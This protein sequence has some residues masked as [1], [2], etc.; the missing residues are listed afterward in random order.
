MNQLWRFLHLLGTIAWL[1]GAFSSMVIGAR[2]KGGSP[3]VLGTVAGLQSA[4]H[5]ILIGPGALVVALSGLILTL[6]LIGNPAPNPWLMAMQGTGLLGAL[7]VLFV[8][9]PTA[10]KLGRIS[11][12]GQTGPLF[13]QLRKRQAMVGSIAGTLGLIALLAGAML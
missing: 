9:V 12:A 4:L 13:E 7:L 10:A 5:R 11:P 3:E 8:S 1:G 2:A 6:R